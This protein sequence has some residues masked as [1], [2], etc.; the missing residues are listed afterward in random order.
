MKTKQDKT[1][2]GWKL[3]KLKKE[4]WRIFSV[5]VRMRDKGVCFTCGKKIPDYFDRYG[6]EKPG[7]K[8]AHAGHYITAKTCGLA[9]YF[10]ERNVHCQGY[11][12]N[13]NLSGNWLEYRKKMI[14]VY[15]VEETE[16]IEQ[17][18]WTGNVKY[19]KTDYIEIIHKYAEKVTVLED[20]A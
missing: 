11:H 15:G 17:L 9:L 13:V 12:C 3:N 6:N 5:Y 14:E 4:L 7:W 1:M 2:M 8:S 18:K 10:H 19:S 20:L 16:R